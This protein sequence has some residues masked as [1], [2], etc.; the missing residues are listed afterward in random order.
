MKRRH[1]PAPD[2][3][4][5]FISTSSM[6]IT[7]S[8]SSTWMVIIVTTITIIIITIVFGILLK[9]TVNVC[10]CHKYTVQCVRANSTQYSACSSCITS[11]MTATVAVD[12]CTLPAPSVIGTRCT[13]CTP[14][15]VCYHIVWYVSEEHIHDTRILS[16]H[17]YLFNLISSH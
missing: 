3:L 16:Y 1:S 11:G 8:T 5:V 15:C 13:R 9:I 17:I 12:V 14:A 10:T 7:T 2:D 6:L 4:A